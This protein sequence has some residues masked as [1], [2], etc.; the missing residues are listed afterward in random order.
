MAKQT[1]KILDTKAEQILKIEVEW[2]GKVA[3]F[4]IKIYPTLNDVLKDTH[5]SEHS[6]VGDK[7]LLLRVMLM[8]IGDY[9][10]GHADEVGFKKEDYSL[11]DTEDNMEVTT[12]VSR[13][14]RSFAWDE[15]LKKLLKHYDLW[16]FKVSWAWYLGDKTAKDNYLKLRFEGNGVTLDDLSGVNSETKAQEEI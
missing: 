13:A 3:D 1:G 15:A 16:R 11:F 8:E 14:L 7:I 10:G 5:L 6:T 12:W 2:W 9:C 4:F